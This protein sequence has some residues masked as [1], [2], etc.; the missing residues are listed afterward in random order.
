LFLAFPLV[1][2]PPTIQ[3]SDIEIIRSENMVRRWS[4]VD[5]FLISFEID[6]SI[7]DVRNPPLRRRK[8]HPFPV[9]IAGMIT[10]PRSTDFC[11]GW[12]SRRSADGMGYER[13][14]SLNASFFLGVFK[15]TSS[16]DSRPSEASTFNFQKIPLGISVARRNPLVGFCVGC[17][18]R[19]QF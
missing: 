6:R 10:S 8:H 7:M 16:F 11:L 13:S 4:P 1:N 5:T 15:D 18:I 17:F 19:S 14:Y 3:P 9:L 12:L 2:K